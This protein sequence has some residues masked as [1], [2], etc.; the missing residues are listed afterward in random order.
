MQLLES[1]DEYKD[2]V[3]EF[4]Q[5]NRRYFSNVYFMRSDMERYIRLGRV[6]Y[7]KAE[8][9]V[10]F[11]FDEEK[12]YRVCFYVSNEEKFFIGKQKKKI[13]IKKG[14]KEKVYRT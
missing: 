9:A 14:K 4:R 1:Y 7:E 8:N 10:I 13:L 3:G 12:Y 6:S 2:I 5:K 11:Y